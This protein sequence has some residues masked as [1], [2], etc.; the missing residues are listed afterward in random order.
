MSGT[1]TSDANPGSLVSHEITYGYEDSNAFKPTISI[2]FNNDLD[3][4]TTTDISFY[5][6]AGISDLEITE[7]KQKGWLVD[8]I[9]PINALRRL[10]IL[11]SEDNILTRSN[12]NID[13]RTQGQNL[14]NINETEYNILKMRRKAE[15]LKYNKNRDN[16]QRNEYSY[17][18]NKKLSRN[19]L[20][21]IQ[22]SCNNTVPIL[23]SSSNSGIVG[24]NSTLLYYNK[25]T[26][27]Y[28]TI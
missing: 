1:T 19:K 10:R 22:T 15:V 6:I 12:R 17:Y 25:D 7:I 5:D 3:T 21:R 4:I 14:R 28:S 26:K 16:N 20:N 9:Q 27:Y 8:P 23:N 13:G 18:V 24:N 11:K 2:L